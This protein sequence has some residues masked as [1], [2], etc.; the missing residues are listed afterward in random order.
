MTIRDLLLNFLIGLGVASFVMFASILESIPLW[1]IVILAAILWAFYVVL[2]IR[3]HSRDLKYP[4]VRY[5]PQH[6][7]TARVSKAPQ[8]VPYNQEEANL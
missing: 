3:D 6:E 7:R 1:I 4:I 2:V 5:R 8:T